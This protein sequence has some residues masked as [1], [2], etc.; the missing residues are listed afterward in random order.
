MI[1]FREWLFKSFSR[2]MIS[3]NFK[4][5][6][7]ITK[8]KMHHQ[9]TPPAII[10]LRNDV[11]IYVCLI[12]VFSVYKSIWKA[13]LWAVASVLLLHRIFLAKFTLR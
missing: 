5:I 3:A 1:I 10:I 9:I 11:I 4:K 2:G 13:H 7:Q 12:R 6:R 8:F